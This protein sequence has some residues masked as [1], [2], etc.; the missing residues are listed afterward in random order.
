MQ[1]AVDFSMSHSMPEWHQEARCKEQPQEMFFGVETDETS[2]KRHRPTLTMSEVKRA[3]ALCDRC[4]VRKQ[5]LEY[6]LYNHE[7]YGVWGGTTKRDRERWW[8]ENDAE[9]ARRDSVDLT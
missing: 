3:V 8:R 1:S 9:W 4:P 5:C 6:A 7:E 2:T